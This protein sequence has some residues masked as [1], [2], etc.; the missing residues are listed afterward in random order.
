MNPEKAV[1]ALAS[2]ETNLILATMLVFSWLVII[3]LYRRVVEVSKEYNQ[4]TLHFASEFKSLVTDTNA[5]I[6][7]STEMSRQTVRL[8]ED[9]NRI[10][11]FVEGLRK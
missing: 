7:A 8:L 10:T 9:P 2:G 11:R 6:S 5:V 4:A 3:V 1:E